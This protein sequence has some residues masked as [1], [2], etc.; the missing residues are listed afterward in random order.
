MQPDEMRERYPAIF[1]AVRVNA[2]PVDVDL[3]R[4]LVHW[5]GDYARLK[6]SPGQP[7]VP[8][9]LVPAQTALA[10][11]VAVVSDSRRREQDGLGAP[12]VVAFEYE[13]CTTPTDAAA[14][15][16]LSPDTVRWHRRRGNLDGRRVGR[17][18][19]VS[20]ASVE[21]LKTRLDERRGA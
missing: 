7:G 1:A 12:E 6:Q 8:E 21:A 3:V 17:S 20:T 19:L 18:W 5:L 11:A 13:Q 15:L 2:I 10:E 4:Y 16:G 14:T 9:G